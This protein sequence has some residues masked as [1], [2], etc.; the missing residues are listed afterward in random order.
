MLL[1]QIHDPALAQYAYLIGCPKSGE[2]LLVD[3]QRDIDRYIALAD[4]NGLEITRVAETHIHADFL[5]GTREFLEQ[6]ENVIAY[7]SDMGDED[8]KYGWADEYDRIQLLKDGD[9]IE[10]GSV[11]VSAV[12]TPGHTP[13]H[14]SFSILDGGDEATMPRCVLTGDFIFVGDTGRPDLLDTAAG[15]D[16]TREP[17]ARDLYSSVQKMKDTH[18]GVMILPG[19]GAGSSC[20][21]ALGAVPFSTFGYEKKYNESITTALEE[22]EDAF[23]GEILEGQPEPPMYFSRMKELNRDGVPVLGGIPDPKRLDR[24]PD[25]S[26]AVFLDTRNDRVEFMRGHLKNS[27]H[28]PLATKFSEAAGSYVDPDSRI[29]LVVPDEEGVREA[30]LQL[31]RIGIDNVCGYVLFADLPSDQLVSTRMIGTTEMNPGSTILDVRGAD[32]YEEAHVPGAINVAHTR[33]VADSDDLPPKGPVTVHCGSGVRAALAASQLERAGYEVTY[34]NGMF[35]DW[36]AQADEVV[37]G[38]S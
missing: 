22:G 14:L 3:P 10:F 25:D 37:V 5:A 38:E 18:D 13:E 24:I 4:E 20:G 6:C 23:V 32:E 17:A 15:G 11:I 16:N 36:K 27:L 19:H 30:V 12:H 9:T 26:N 2:A 29:Y 8:W 35:A 33:L 34:A 7:L 31:I 28:T 1:R 21:K